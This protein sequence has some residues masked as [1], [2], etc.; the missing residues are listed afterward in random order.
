MP[1]PEQSDGGSSSSWHALV[2]RYARSAGIDL[3]PQTVDELAAHLEDLYLAARDRGADHHAARQEAIQE[4]EASGLLPLRIE[5]RPDSRATHV[6]LANDISSAS[7]SRSFAMGYALRM[8]LRQFRL[9][10]AFAAITILVL[11]P[12]PGQRRWCIR[13]WIR[14]SFGRFPI[15]RPT[16]S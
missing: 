7:R 15:A 5:P 9:H 12:A 3:S 6:R 2:A 13:L 14:S 1:E 16:L 4:L 11:G 10:P 8:A